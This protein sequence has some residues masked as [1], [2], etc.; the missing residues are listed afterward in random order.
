[1]GKKMKSQHWQGKHINNRIVPLRPFVQLTMWD[2]SIPTPAWGNPCQFMIYAW[3]GQLMGEWTRT[4]IVSPKNKGEPSASLHDMKK[5]WRIF[6]KWCVWGR[7]TSPPWEWARPQNLQRV[8]WVGIIACRFP[9]P[10]DVKRKT[11]LVEW[12]HGKALTVLSHPPLLR[13][14]YS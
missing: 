14:N 12:A 13:N 5:W 11:P 2:H 10:I 9:T 1:M 3:G 6:L 8:E 4:R 7:K